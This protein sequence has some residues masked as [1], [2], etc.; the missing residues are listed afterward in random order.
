MAEAA[1][2]KALGEDGGDP[3]STALSPFFEPIVERLLET[4]D[5]T[6]GTAANLRS[7]AYEALMEMIKNSAQDNYLTVQKTTKVSNCPW[8][9]D[10]L[11]V[12]RRENPVFCFRVNTILPSNGEGKN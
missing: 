9:V 2:D 8:G 10:L 5:R 6:D 4:T 12:D 1:Y 7:A 3:P 11:D